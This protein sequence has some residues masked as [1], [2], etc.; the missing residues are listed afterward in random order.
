MAELG[1][2][3]AQLAAAAEVDEGTL[4]DFLNHKRRPRRVTLGKLAAALGWTLDTLVGDGEELAVLGEA[5][6]G[7]AVLGADLSGVS[8]DELVAELSERLRVLQRRVRDLEG[9]GR[10]D[11]SATGSVDEVGNVR[12]LRRG[13]MP[14]DEA[15][16]DGS[17]GDD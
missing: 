13:A 3:Q 9:R 6:L 5:R 11:A 12:Q 16:Y 7:S 15:A 8:S 10:E 1:M 14:V 4:S 2:T 17:D